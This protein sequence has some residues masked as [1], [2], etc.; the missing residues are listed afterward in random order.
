MQV[1][2]QL[3]GAKWI[4]QFPP[5]L[6]HWMGRRRVSIST[7]QGAHAPQRR[8]TFKALWL[9]SSFSSER[10]FDSSMQWLSK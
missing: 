3:R 1:R 10:D 4:T 7:L 5:E 6:K 2:E 8:R 9:L